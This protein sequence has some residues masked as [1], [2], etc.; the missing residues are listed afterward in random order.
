MALCGALYMAFLLCCAWD[1]SSSSIFL[2]SYLGRLP[3]KCKLKRHSLDKDY[4]HAG[5]SSYKLSH[6]FLDVALLVN[7]G[8]S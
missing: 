8:L 1:G 2:R 4:N 5:T 3:L 7:P 6:F